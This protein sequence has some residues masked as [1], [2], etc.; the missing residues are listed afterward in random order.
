MPN[1]GSLKTVG[2]PVH[3]FFRSRRVKSV[4][5]G[6]EHTNCRVLPVFFWFWLALGP[7]SKMAPFGGLSLAESIYRMA[8]EV[9]VERKTM[10][11]ACKGT[12]TSA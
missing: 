6:P 7:L 1:P 8:V 3:V 10:V 9:A 2:A 12:L 5:G 11:L 4:V